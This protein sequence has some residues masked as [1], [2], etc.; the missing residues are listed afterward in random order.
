MYWLV[1]F[2]DVLAFLL[3]LLDDPIHSFPK[4]KSMLTLIIYFVVEAVDMYDILELMK[5][6]NGEMY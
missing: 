1:L 4:K 2:V 6:M 3:S 5:M